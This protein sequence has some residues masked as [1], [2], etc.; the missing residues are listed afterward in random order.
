MKEQG[1]SGKWQITSSS[2]LGLICLLGLFA[3][4]SWAQIKIKNR[5][6]VVPGQLIVKYKASV[7]ENVI[8]NSLQ[9]AG[10]RVIR[11]SEALGVFL[12]A[13]NVVTVQAAIDAVQACQADPNIEYV[14]PNYYL[15]A[16]ETMAEREPFAL[17]QGSPRVPNDP[18]FGELWNM[19]NSNDADIDGPEAWAT[20]TGSNDVLVAIIDT[21]IDYNHEDLQEQMWRNP[22]ESGNGKENNGVDDDNNGYQDDYRGWNFVFDNNDPYDN[23]GHGTHC[24]GVVGAVGNNGRGIAGVNW[25]VKMMAIKFL[26]QNGSGTTQ[27]AAEAIIYATKM[28]AKVLSNSWGGGENSR[29]LQ[30][31]IQF[32]SDRGVLFIAAA[33]NESSNTDRVANY[34]ST[35]NVPNVVAV[36]SSDRNDALSSFS[37]YGRYTVDLAA[38]GSSILSAQPLNRY[39]LLSGTSMATPH[40]AGVAA[41]IWAQYPTLTMHQVLVRLLGSTDRKN[42]FIGRMVTGGR[43]NAAN[44]FSTNPL[45]AFTTDLPYTNN[46][47]GPY[48]VNTSAVD[49]GAITNVKLVYSVNGATSDSV[50]MTSIGNDSYTADIPGKPL[51]TVIN[52]LVIATDNDG[53]RTASPTYT[54]RVTNEQPPEEGCCG[55]SAVAFDGLDSSMRWALEIPA[56]IAF[57]L[58]PLVLLR[59]RQK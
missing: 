9:E 35:Y 49:D 39:Q 45:I 18:R 2:F 16:I 58:L 29:T 43:L 36:A 33:G 57:F 19:R 54:F 10:L 46:T 13:T 21:G 32:A 23:N 8:Q 48:K 38:P 37:N 56:N 25:R 7:E 55:G 3:A 53:N 14:E 27:D 51:E 47:V 28:G 17:K 41:L 12:C 26:D 6:R 44:A 4:T 30:D 5:P 40:V 20:Q 42:A 50:N 24:A 52:Y 1:V 22:G 15:Y 59:R 11:S 31:A 34:P